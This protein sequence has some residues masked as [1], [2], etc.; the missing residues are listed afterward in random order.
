VV[1]LT[2]EHPVAPMAGL[3]PE[4]GGLARK[5][6]AVSLL[7]V[8]L[9]LLMLIPYSVVFSPLGGA[10]GLSTMYAAILLFLFLALWLHQGFHIDR[11]TQPIRVAGIAFTCS[12]IAAYVS[13]N[14]H[15]IPSLERNGADR[16][17]IFAAGWLAVLLLAADGIDRPDRLNTMLGRIVTGVTAM[18]AVG[19]AE[20]ATGL[21]V[22]QYIVIPGFST[23]TIATATA[24]ST[25][26]GFNRPAATAA[27]PLE[28]ATVLAI[29]LPIALHRARFA[30]PGLRF[31]RWVQ[32]GVI[33]ACLPLTISRAA[34]LGLAVVFLVMLP[35][36]PKRHRRYVY[37]G[38]VA[39]F[40]GIFV[41][42]P[43]LLSTFFSLF[44][45]S[46]ATSST[47][48]RTNAY[49][50]AA[51]YIAQHPWLGRGFGTFLPQ[52]YFFTDNQYLSTLIETG[53]IGLLALMA[54][55][56]TG[57]FVG[58]SAYH[59]AVHPEA[60]DLAQSLVA[61]V[62]AASLAFATF[63]ALSFSIAAGLSFL[64]L[65]CVGAAW[66]M[67]RNGQL[68]GA[69]GDPGD[70]GGGAPAAAVAGGQPGPSEV[71][72]ALNNGPVS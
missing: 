20:F 9:V 5:F 48:S 38:L 72:E 59:S 49:G 71:Q 43:R 41:V 56:V 3:P 37:A 15:L 63:D 4:R 55:F 57:W 50:S 60:R 39:A 67:I 52:T 35:T 61:S 46:G 44:A 25:R 16:G 10:G 34:I 7:T 42:V 70:P 8:Y 6:D 51:T 28:L 64:I 12:I 24:V 27:H 11:G 62:A 19:I 18:A 29:G 26:L 17:L 32:V 13:V 33:G 45:G 66:R 30:P 69:L 23:Q 40:L 58:R 1:T 31:R 2:G 65:G 53:I 22:T 47:A 68:E 36:W 54:L 14:R 21:D